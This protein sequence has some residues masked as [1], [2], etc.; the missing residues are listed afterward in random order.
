MRK[1]SLEQK[2]IRQHAEN[3]S[4]MRDIVDDADRTRSTLS[5]V[6]ENLHSLLTDPKFAALLRNERL[7][8]MPK[9]LR[10]LLSVRQP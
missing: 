5:E 2:L 7:G 4:R 3:S 8:R 1:W 6:V 10:D 9:V